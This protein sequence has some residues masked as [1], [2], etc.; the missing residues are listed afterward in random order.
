MYETPF[1]ELELWFLAPHSTST[2][3]CEMTIAPKMH[4]GIDWKF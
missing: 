4:S 2:Y 1:W 3:T